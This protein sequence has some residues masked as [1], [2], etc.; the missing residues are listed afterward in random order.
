M[1]NGKNLVKTNYL[2]KVGWAKINKQKILSEIILICPPN[3][4]NLLFQIKVFQ[5]VI[6]SNNFNISKG[7]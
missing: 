4:I 3:K 5:K 2:I 1:T 6:R 7:I